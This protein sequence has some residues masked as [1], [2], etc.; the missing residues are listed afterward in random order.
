MRT[1]LTLIIY[2]LVQGCFVPASTSWA[3]QASASLPSAGG[4]T[5]TVLFTNIPLGDKTVQDLGDTYLLSKSHDPLFFQAYEKL[6]AG[7]FGRLLRYREA[8]GGGGQVDLEFVYQDK[9]QS[10]TILDYGSGRFFRITFHPDEK[11]SFCLFPSNDKLDLTKDP[12]TAPSFSSKW[13]L[14]NQRVPGWALP[15]VHRVLSHP[16]SP[17]EQESWSRRL[18]RGPPGEVPS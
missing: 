10:L 15:E 13:A 1:I 2:T 4:P 3:A 14:S 6:P 18:V 8:L 12:S 17:T 16:T 11:E 7:G 5:P 9:L